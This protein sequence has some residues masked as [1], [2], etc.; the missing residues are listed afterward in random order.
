MPLADEHRPLSFDDM[1][2]QQHLVG[3]GGILRN[4]ADSHSLQS[5]IFY[6]PPGTGK[7]TAALILA[8][9][10]NKPLHKLN[11]VSA[12]TSD[13]KKVAESAPNTGC[14]L[15][16]DEIQY[17]NK[18]QQ[19]S[20]LPYVESGAVTL[21]AS[22]TENPYHDVYDAILSRCLVLEFKRIAPEDI[23]Q[24]LVRAVL[25][26]K[27]GLDDI[28]TDVLNFIAQIASG[29]VRRAFNTLEL[30]AA[31]FAGRLSNVTVQDVKG[32]LPSAQM[33]GF[34]MDGDSHYSY[35]SAL[36]KSIRGSDPDGAVFYLTKL[37]EGGDIV[38]PSRR[39]LVIA[40]EDIGLAYPGAIEHTLACVRA[41]E[42]LGLPEAYKPL[43]QAAIL[44]ANAPKSNSNEPAY[45]AA[46]EDIKHGLGTTVPWYLRTS[47][48][49]GYLYPHQYPDHWVDQQ[50]LPDDIADRR[51]YVP[52]DNPD[53]QQSAEYWDY[54][55]RKH[56]GQP[57]YTK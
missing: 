18:K 20:L 12:G 27:N 42:M 9:S 43:T 54:I 44:L 56:G 26:H 31:Q 48:A 55:R 41:A 25:S 6:G 11:G 38:S 30:V 23:Y 51:Y 22:T 40:C 57:K 10:A 32:L 13:I 36:Q 19:Q 46:Q 28:P 33:A 35:I 50:Y 16:L 14:V 29:D 17:L 7:T 47:C 34:D 37:L 4:M 15:Y 2:G 52:G 45:M 8:D 53:E 39:L 49:P 5:V 3:P 21:I 24:R 1:V